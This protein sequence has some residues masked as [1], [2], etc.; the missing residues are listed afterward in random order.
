MVAVV[1]VV[2]VVIAV[3]VLAPVVGV[4]VVVVEVVVVVPTVVGM[5]VQSH[6]QQVFSTSNTL[7]SHPGLHEG[8]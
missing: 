3:F 8:L 1:P 2:V 6:V 7:S 4:L 5:G